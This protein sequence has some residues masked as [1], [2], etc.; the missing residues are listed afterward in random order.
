MSALDLL[1]VV[2]RL[3]FLVVFVRGATP[4][5]AIFPTP[6]PSRRGPERQSRP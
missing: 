4:A 5:R 1:N 6:S 2:A 3:L